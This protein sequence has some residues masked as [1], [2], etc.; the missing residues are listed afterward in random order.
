MNVN[1]V[2]LQV[3]VDSLDLSN[4]GEKVLDFFVLTFSDI[5]SFGKASITFCHLTP[6]K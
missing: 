2:K 6:S 3:Q 4:N 1:S 5:K